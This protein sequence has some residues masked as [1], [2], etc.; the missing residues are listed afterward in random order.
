MV[1]LCLAKSLSPSQ[2][3]EERL[4]QSLFAKYNRDILPEHDSTHPVKIQIG[5]SP[6]AIKGIDVS[7]QVLNLDGWV[8]YRWNDSR[9]SWDPKEYGDMPNIR[10]QAKRLWTPDVTI[11]N[12]MN[13]GDSEWM[14][15]SKSMNTLVYSSG[16]VV[17]VPA[18]SIRA[19]CDLDLTRYPYDVHTCSLKFGSWV[20][21]GFHMD[22][23]LDQG[24]LNKGPIDISNLRNSSE[25]MVVST[26]SV[27][28]VNYY[29][30]CPEPYPS[31]TFNMT[32]RRQADGYQAVI[33]T[34]IA[35]GIILA[36]VTFFISPFQ[37]RRLMLNAFNMLCFLLTTLHLQRQLPSVG[38]ST[39]FIVLICEFMMVILSMSMWWNMI[40]LAIVG[41][42]KRSQAPQMLNRFLNS[43]PTKV[44]FISNGNVSMK[45]CCKKISE[46]NQN[47]K[48]TEMLNIVTE[49]SDAVSGWM[50]LIL[51]ID[52]LG[53]LLVLVSMM[54]GLAILI[55]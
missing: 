30:C 45:E 38:K 41:R 8:V 51:F 53:F 35:C 43:W 20:F 48:D 50:K 2:E 25:W 13:Q 14:E 54:S 42:C 16:L 44:L 39:P 5:F 24:L 12:G 46:L 52:R 26:S 4:R 28:E 19:S 31:V 36:L 49:E 22:L 6:I 18:A 32:L 34:P 33:L 3:N 17:W 29:S 7:S 47:N 21:D 37:A 23:V 9:L 1:H 55:Q 11:Y 40:V 27:K 10:V 15:G